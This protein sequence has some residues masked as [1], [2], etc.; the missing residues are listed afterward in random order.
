MDNGNTENMSVSESEN[1]EITDQA[2]LNLQNYSHSDRSII[3]R[4]LKALTGLF[5]K[6]GVSGVKTA[7]RLILLLF[8]IIG[9]IWFVIT[10]VLGGIFSLAK[11]VFS[12]IKNEF[13]K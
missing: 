4:L 2:I 13:K 9:G 11:H 6:I 12:Y 5:V 3:K 8:K 10:D 7:V 1:I